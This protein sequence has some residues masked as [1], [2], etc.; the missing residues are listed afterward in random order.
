MAQW[1]W[2]KAFKTVHFLCKKKNQ[3]FLQYFL[4]NLF[5]KL[6]Q[7][8]IFYHF[9]FFYNSFLTVWYALRLSQQPTV[10]WIYQNKDWTIRRREARSVNPSSHRII[11]KI[12]GFMVLLERRDLASIMLLQPYVP[13]PKGEHIGHRR[14]P[15]LL[16]HI[17]SSCQKISQPRKL[18]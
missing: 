8:I 16:V 14:N 9:L 6:F 3:F 13:Y 1:L 11:L 5:S 10:S 17:V 12:V 4:Q 7:I 2:L 15:Y 18:Y